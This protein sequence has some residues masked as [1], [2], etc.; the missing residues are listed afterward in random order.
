MK[1]LLLILSATTGIVTA[2]NATD[3][4]NIESTHSFVEFHYNHM[5]FSN[6]SGKWMVNGTLDLDQ[7]NLAKS[8]TNITINIGDIVTGVPKLDEHLK[9]ADFFD[10]TKYPTATFVSQKVS[11]IKGKKFDLNGL[12][13]L[14]GVTK[15]VTLHVTEN[16]IGLNK[17]YDKQTAGFSATAEIKRSDY[18]INLYVPAVSDQIKLDIEIEA[19]LADNKKK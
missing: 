1:K 3:L 18:G 17:V 13:T 11:N 15:P 9:S 6:P 10:A 8:K 12:L 4:Y 16:M 5:G 2:A 14:H 7:K 19:Q